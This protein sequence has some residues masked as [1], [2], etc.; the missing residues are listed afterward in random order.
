MSELAETTTDS[1][2][3]PP[4]I[5]RIDRF[6]RDVRR[7]WEG[8]SSG[9]PGARPSRWEDQVL[10]SSLGQRV[11][12]RWQGGL[13]E[14]IASRHL[15]LTSLAGRIPAAIRAYD[16]PPLF[17][18]LARP[19]IPTAA[20]LGR[21]VGPPRPAMPA[22]RNDPPP[23]DLFAPESFPAPEPAGRPL[24]APVGRAEAGRWRA[25]M[26]APASGSGPS[27]IPRSPAPPS[28]GALHPA[29]T[30]EEDRRSTVPGAPPPRAGAAVAVVPG[31]S[32]AGPAPVAPVVPAARGAR[33][34]PS[35]LDLAFWPR[36][37]RATEPAPRL[38]AEV[39]RRADRAAA[40]PLVNASPG[41][42][43][44]SM[45]A[46]GFPLTTRPLSL[47]TPESA[48]IGARAPEWKPAALPPA[49][50]A[51]G[52]LSEAA[53]QPF[54]V[55]APIGTGDPGISFLDRRSRL[56][57]R[58]SVGPPSLDGTPSVGRAP[59]RE[60]APTPLSSPSA[61]SRQWVGSEAGP[62]T[63][64]G[65]AEG[66][67]RAAG[68]PSG[69]P[70]SAPSGFSGRAL[71]RPPFSGETERPSLAAR[72]EAR[73]L[74]WV[75]RGSAKTATPRAVRSILAPSVAATGRA[76]QAA[77]ATAPLLARARSTAAS[78]RLWPDR[79]AGEGERTGTPPLSIP[80]RVPAPGEEPRAGASSTV[81]AAPFTA[82]VPQ[83]PLPVMRLPGVGR[84]GRS[85]RM[86]SATIQRAAGP[87][88]EASRGT[89]EAP[90]QPSAH[91]HAATDARVA[92]H[93]VQNL[94]NEVWA[95]LKR[96]L[97]AEAE[98]Q[99]GW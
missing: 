51:A 42:A 30:G 43:R 27:G 33:A 74:G 25:A 94:A 84:A 75:E 40:M 21:V 41:P 47:P 80:A 5:A 39:Q 48:R 7:R 87:A 16:L 10:G 60:T 2:A 50:A 65:A 24:G 17:A 35:T 62:A 11:A 91:A 82:A 66:P 59:E 69:Q 37:A 31:R 28:S 61:M 12:D 77:A 85:S 70:T 96:R 13:A 55:R 38:A 23:F 22:D 20:W 93:D 92:A 79:L 19:P 63:L 83:S 34:A 15:S 52:E 98:R 9:R 56:R 64:A 76:P 46:A 58:E 6:H 36:V 99:G 86:A 54:A 3:V 72:L 95:L 57:T 18:R 88:A 71:G 53:R 29:A 67:V 4:S 8:E 14:R 90:A 89:E 1:S 68:V 32:L 81:S 26:P 73:W 78:P 45:A 97:F 49:A 44:L